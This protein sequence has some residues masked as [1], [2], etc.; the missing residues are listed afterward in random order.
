MN[1]EKK[2][3]LL[4]NMAHNLPTLR[5]KAGL[6]QAKLAE[7]V[8]VSRQ[9]LVSVEN[10]KRLMSWYTFLA[11]LLIFKNN[12]E[13]DQLLQ[14]YDISTNELSDYLELNAKSGG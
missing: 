2:E 4:I 9:T 1:D 6:S 8:G 12:A 7:M 11:C 10:E 5:A 14:I 13:T 3:K